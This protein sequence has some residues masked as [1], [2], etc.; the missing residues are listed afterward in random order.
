M[1]HQ[2]LRQEHILESFVY[3]N[4]AARLAATGFVAGDIG[5][6]S[7][8]QDTGQYFRLTSA[9]PTA[10]ALIGPPSA[11]AVVAYASLQ[12][13]QA[14]PVATSSTVGIMLGL[15]VGQTIT[16]SASGKVL[17]TIAGTLLASVADAEAI[18]HW[19][20]GAPP[21]YGAAPSGTP[22]GGTGVTSPNASGTPLSLSGVV[23][24]LTVGAPYWFDLE[25]VASSASGSVRGLLLTTTAVELP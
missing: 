1:R 14:N 8:Q 13:A 9:S 12:T 2:D 16:P 10:W 15:G 24:G 19:G 22:V 7:Y 25:L 21:V 5:R 6:V 23:S 4:A 11:A 3:A 18:M 20:G 17:V